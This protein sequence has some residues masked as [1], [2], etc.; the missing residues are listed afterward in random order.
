[1]KLE[2][3]KLALFKTLISENEFKRFLDY[4]EGINE[5]SIEKCSLF[6]FDDSI[7]DKGVRSQIHQLFK[8]TATFETDTLMEGESRRIRIFLKNSLSQN[9]RRKMNI[10][11]RKT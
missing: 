6:T 2:E 9:K 7:E 4:L 1:M 10:V 3:D 5:G 11:N 8:D